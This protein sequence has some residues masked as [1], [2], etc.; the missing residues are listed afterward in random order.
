VRSMGLGLLADISERLSRNFR[1]YRSG[2]PD[3]VV[4]N[5]AECL[6]V[7][8]KGPGDKLSAKQSIWLDFLIAIGAKTEV[9]R[10]KSV[11][12]KRIRV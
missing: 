4:W 7:E 3:L 6:F 9:C 2:F 8:V 12:N 1:H 5:E 10:V 11:S